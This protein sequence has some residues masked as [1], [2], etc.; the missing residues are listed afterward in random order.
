MP[1]HVAGINSRQ[2]RIVTGPTAKVTHSLR[3][4]PRRLSRFLDCFYAGH[5]RPP[6]GSPAPRDAL[7]RI[8]GIRDEEVALRERLASAVHQARQDGATWEHIAGA[9]GVSEQSA[10][11]RFGNPQ[12]NQATK[13]TPPP[14]G[15]AEL[16][17]ALRGRGLQVI[18]QR[19]VGRYR[20][21][22]AC[23]PVAY[24]VWGSNSR[25]HG[26]VD[27][28]RRIVTLIKAGWSVCYWQI[29]REPAD[30][31]A[32]LLEGYRSLVLSLHAPP[33]ALVRDAEVVAEGWVNDRQLEMVCWPDSEW[34]A[35]VASTAATHRAAVS[36][37]DEPQQR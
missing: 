26:A 10:W 36:Q 22:S 27:Q 13:E 31:V 30:A 16:A 6:R 4:H 33:Y 32:Q 17:D 11:D 28:S 5:G 29:G 3:Q 19:R 12:A 1:S 18:T 37:G 8:H 2:G 23:W 14:L 24:E 25:P 7:D 9:L 21:D 35:F 15:E 20:I 34:R